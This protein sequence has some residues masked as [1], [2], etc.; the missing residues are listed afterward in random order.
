VPAVFA[1]VHF[2]RYHNHLRGRE[3]LKAE[4]ALHRLFD[5]VFAKSE[6]EQSQFA[7][8]SLADLY[9]R[10]GFADEALQIVAE[11]VR[12]C[13]RLNDS[14]SLATALYFEGRLHQ[15]KRLQASGAA[16]SSPAL[17]RAVAVPIPLNLTKHE[18][19][20]TALSHQRR[21]A[22]LGVLRSLASVDVGLGLVP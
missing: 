16:S 3:L 12:T 6:K 5:Y 20:L 11:A 9:A 19:A 4:E 14:E 17:D 18:K 21:I 13:R 7:L 10:F 8:L 2:V 22:Y 15:L 1:P